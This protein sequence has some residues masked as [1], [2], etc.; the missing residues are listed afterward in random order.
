[1]KECNIQLSDKDLNALFAFFDQ[2]GN[3]S[4]SYDEFLEGVRGEINE[5]RMGLIMLA[6]NVIDKD[7]NGVLEPADIVGTYDASRHPDVLLGRKT[8]DEVLAEFLDTFDVGGEKDGMVTKNE[9]ANYYKNISASI[10]RDDYFELM[11][12]NAWHISGGEGWSENSANVRVFVVH[13]DG[14]EGVV[15]IKNDLGL[16]PGDKKEAML[17]LRRQGLNPQSVSFFDDLQ[18]EEPKPAE[19]KNWK[20]TFTLG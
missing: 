20:T 12:R 16:K 13:K 18:K 9:F 19:N 1:M 6:F 10:D 7:G 15:E 17:R 14:S 11:I 3:G 2:D 8:P 5:K 4:I